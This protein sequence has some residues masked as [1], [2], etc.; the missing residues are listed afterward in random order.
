MTY[1]ISESKGFPLQI[2]LTISAVSINQEAV[3]EH[4]DLKSES[5][6]TSAQPPSGQEPVHVPVPVQPDSPASQRKKSKI[7]CPGNGA[8]RKKDDVL[9]Q[10]TPV[11]SASGTL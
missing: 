3:K 6:S 7:D 8:C 4:L 11:G 1:Q 10:G 5:I 2:V 9:L